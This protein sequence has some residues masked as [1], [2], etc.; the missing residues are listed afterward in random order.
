MNVYLRKEEKIMRHAVTIECLLLAS[1]SSSISQEKTY[2]ITNT[3]SL[4]QNIKECLSFP[5]EKRRG[6]KRRSLFFFIII[7]Q[8]NQSSSIRYE[9]NNFIVEDLSA[10]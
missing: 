9:K 2:I 1:S 3:Q 10:K 5:N 8:N 6:K 4:E 7:R